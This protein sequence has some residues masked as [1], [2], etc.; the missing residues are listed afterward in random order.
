MAGDG[1]TRKKRSRI[2]ASKLAPGRVA[3]RL[4]DDCATPGLAPATPEGDP[5]AERADA[6]EDS[7]TQRAKTVAQT[8]TAVAA[9]FSAVVAAVDAIGR[10]L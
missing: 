10:L 5:N 7:R 3:S 6:A 2:G 4:V 1:N 9:A 8:V